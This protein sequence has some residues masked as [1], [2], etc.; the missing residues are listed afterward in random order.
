MYWS[1][2]LESKKIIINKINDKEVNI[3]AK[4]QSNCVGWNIKILDAPNQ[5]ILAKELLDIILTEEHV[6]QNN[7]HSSWNIT[8][9]NM[10][11]DCR[12]FSGV[13]SRYI[14]L[15]LQCTFL[16]EK[17]DEYKEFRDLELQCGCHYT[18]KDVEPILEESQE[19][20]ESQKSSEYDNS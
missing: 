4:I 20:E 1:N 3:K 19:S 13:C 9:N 16:F 6:K 11:F 5:D 10:R 18:K 17:T 8:I 2:A 15:C 12:S 7:P 14:M